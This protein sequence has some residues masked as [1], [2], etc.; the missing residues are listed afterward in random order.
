M[1]SE[2][3]FIQN[4]R[5]LPGQVEMQGAPLELGRILSTNGYF[6]VREGLYR[7]QEVAVKTPV[8]ECGHPYVAFEFR[9]E[10]ELLLSLPLHRNIVSC[11]GTVHSGAEVTLV[12]EKAD[13]SMNTL[14]CDLE[15]ALDWTIRAR[16]SLDV[17]RGLQHLHDHGILH[18]DLKS[19]NVLVFLG[20]S[21]DEISAKL[22]DFGMC[23]PTSQGSALGCVPHSC[24]TLEWSA[25][26]TLAAGDSANLS[27]SYTA[28]S[29]IQRVL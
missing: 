22:C 13:M 21:D 28:A 23:R 7:G 11:L 8:P 10:I 24:G 5:S 20:E 16:L 17:A 14:L 9:R 12:L 3:G 2:L 1:E 29:G 4:L 26:E 27:N 25:P 6:I 19:G 18:G 15:Y